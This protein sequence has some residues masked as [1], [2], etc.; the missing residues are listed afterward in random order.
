MR[1][2]SRPTAKRSQTNPS[3]ED[4]ADEKREKREASEAFDGTAL[5][6]FF[7]G[8]GW[9]QAG[10]VLLVL[11]VP[12]H[13]GHSPKDPMNPSNQT[14]APIGRVQ[15]DDPRTD[16]I[17]LFGPRQQG[18]RKGSI[19]W[20]GR[21][22]QKQERQARPTTDERV[23]PEASQKGKRMMSGSVPIGSIRVTTS[24]GQDGSAVNDEITGSDEPSSESLQNHQHKQ[25]L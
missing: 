10:A 1:H 11:G 19:V 17:E 7:S 3:G 8:P 4:V 21:R 22:K 20:V 23:D 14:Q 24:P 12:R 5:A 18:L 15:T 25:G 6:K 2:R 13:N 9:G 16:L